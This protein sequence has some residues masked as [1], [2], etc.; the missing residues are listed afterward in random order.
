M[1]L[2]GKRF[3][4]LTVLED[5]GMYN[6]EPIL[7]CR[8]QCGHRRKVLKSNLTNGTAT[9]CGCKR[10]GRKRENIEGER[11]GRLV[12]KKYEFDD[13]RHN[14]CWLFQCDCGNEK[15]LSVNQVKWSGVKSCG[16]LRRERTESLNKKDLSGKCFG[17]LTAIRPTDNR[18]N[19]GTIIWECRCDC[20][21]T[22]YYSVNELNNGNVHSCGCLYRETRASCTQKREDLIDDTNVTSLVVA[23]KTR[24]NNTS[25]VTGVYLNKTNNKWVAYLSYKKKRYYLGMFTNKDDAIKARKRTEKELHDPMI[26]EHWDE[27]SEK[28]Q[29][30]YLTYLKGLIPEYPPSV[31]I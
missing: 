2:I 20:G 6:N 17:R 10:R 13:K 14:A 19:P 4:D 3:G 24:A 30:D 28:R 27:L 12:A 31:N 11:F 18:D 5:A 26:E 1:N 16:C 8:C 15:I 25:G 22:A 9:H 23:K 29:A 7:L 21:N